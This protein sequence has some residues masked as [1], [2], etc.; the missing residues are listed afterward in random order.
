MLSLCFHL[1]Y[2]T[3]T[4][5]LSLVTCLTASDQPCSLQN[6]HNFSFPTSWLFSLESEQS[7]VIED[8]NVR[9]INLISVLMGSETDYGSF[10]WTSVVVNH[11]RQSTNVYHDPKI[12]HYPQ[13]CIFLFVLCKVTSSKIQ[14]DL[15]IC[16]T[17]SVNTY[18][19]LR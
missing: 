5:Y 15:Q 17:Y 8:L 10:Y 16:I 11:R 2:I 6:N 13:T 9:I 7:E 3:H 14:S 1:Q 4:C 12:F 18:F 19:N